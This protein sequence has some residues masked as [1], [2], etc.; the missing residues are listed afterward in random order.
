MNFMKLKKVFSTCSFVRF[1]AV[2][3][4]S[5]VVCVGCGKSKNNGSGDGAS[6][7]FNTGVTLAGV[8]GV[9]NDPNIV[10]VS[11]DGLVLSRPRA[12]EIFNLQE[13]G[14]RPIFSVSELEFEAAER[15]VWTSLRASDGSV[16]YVDRGSLEVVRQWPDGRSFVEGRIE[17]TRFSELVAPRVGRDVFVRI[18]NNTQTCEGVEHSAGRMLAL[19]FI[20]D[21]AASENAT[22]SAVRNVLSVGSSEIFDVRLIPGRPLA[23]LKFDNGRVVVVRY[24]TRIFVDQ[25]SREGG[26]PVRAFSNQEVVIDTLAQNARIPTLRPDIGTTVVDSPYALSMTRVSLGQGRFRYLVDGDI[27]V[28]AA[29]YEPEELVASREAPVALHNPN[30]DRENTAPYGLRSQQDR[31]Q[32]LRALRLS[33]VQN[34]CARLRAA[35]A[36]DFQITQ[37]PTNNR[38][39]CGQTVQ[40]YTLSTIFNT[41]AFSDFRER[42]A[43]LQ[44]DRSLR[45]VC[46]AQMTLMFSLQ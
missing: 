9:E 18:F 8:Q 13:L 26:Q 46:A 25:E 31:V 35:L 36:R 38:S 4:L 19:N 21:R 10:T 11:S 27:E 41:R 34:D 17:S 1:A 16:R 3:S 15:D 39:R 22:D 32:Q 20:D 28:P 29:A 43:A 24:G 12:H 42:N 40:E 44:F 23:V 45:G 37:A 2:V 7:S 6:N 14:A 33:T 5:A 30:L